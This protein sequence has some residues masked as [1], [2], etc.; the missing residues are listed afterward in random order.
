MLV[1]SLLLLLVLT[2]LAVAA[3]QTTR[4]QERMAWNMRD[5][6]LAFQGA[7]AG[8]RAA[9]KFLATP[10]SLT[11]LNP[12]SNPADENCFVL[13]QGYFT[14]IDLTRENSSWWTSNARPYGDA[15]AQE[16]SDVTEEPRFVI[17]ELETIPFS[18]KVGHGPPP[19]KTYYK[20]TA[21]SPGGTNTSV[22]VVESVFARE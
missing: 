16:I 13:E 10:P 22:A 1:V 7:E 15:S 20:S 3:S 19:G 17:E 9:E 11:A 12:C 14:D 5:V 4:L 2:I 6:D 18:L 21:R 8:L